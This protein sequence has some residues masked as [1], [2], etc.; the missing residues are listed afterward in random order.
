MK[1]PSTQK[2]ATA[3]TKAYSKINSDDKVV[4]LTARNT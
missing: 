1:T 3:R 2:V 4:V